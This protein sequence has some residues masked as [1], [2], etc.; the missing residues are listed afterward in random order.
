MGYL[1]ELKDRIYVTGYESL[2][3]AENIG[4]TLVVNT[5][6][7]VL[8][9][10]KNLQKMQLKILQKKVFKNQQKQLWVNW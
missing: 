2:S 3:F 5:V 6:K 1:I 9:V 4:K 10:L 8:I 7:N